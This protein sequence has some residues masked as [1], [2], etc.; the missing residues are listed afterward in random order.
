M[1]HDFGFDIARFDLPVDEEYVEEEP[2]QC[3]WC[4]EA[5]GSDYFVVARGKH[6]SL[7][8]LCWGRSPV[9][10]ELRQEGMAHESALRQ[11]GIQSAT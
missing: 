1:P 2:G 9:Y 3:D 7:C 6:H 5:R 8:P 11:L 10:Q 4:G